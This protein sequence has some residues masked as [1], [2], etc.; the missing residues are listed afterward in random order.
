MSKALYYILYAFT[1]T[2]S[3]LPFWVLYRISDITYLLLFYMIHY[4]KRTVMRNLKKSFPEK[5]QEETHILAKKFYRHFC[6]FMFESIKCISMSV[7]QH[8]KRYRYMN[9]ELIHDLGRKNRSIHDSIIRLLRK[10]KKRKGK[11]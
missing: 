8:D 3:L 6:D 7:K 9:L 1:W 11:I 4:R 2:V 5:T 10:K